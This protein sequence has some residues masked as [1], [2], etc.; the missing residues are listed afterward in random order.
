MSFF[1]TVNFNEPA[2]TVAGDKVTLRLPLPSDFEEWA[3]LRDASRDFLVP[4]EPTWPVDDLTRS[5]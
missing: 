2:L 4:W 3:A 1:R 5:C